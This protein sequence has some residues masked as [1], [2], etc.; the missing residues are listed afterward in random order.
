M[1]DVRDGEAEGRDRPR[2]R[3]RWG[4]FA[5]LAAAPVLIVGTLVV[6][7]VAFV[8]TDEEDVGAYVAEKADCG[9]ALA[10][11]GAALPEGAR[12]ESCT[13][14]RGIDTGYTAVFRMPRADVRGWLA[15]TYPA[16]P[17]PR[18]GCVDAD[19]DLCLD[20]G[21]SDALPPDVDAH[22]VQVTVEHSDAR[23]ALVRFSAFTI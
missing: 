14:A 5:A 17:A 11:G 15:G 6:G 22:G 23:T 1:T 3:T 21:H 8:L 16:A 12:T 7:L 9:Q 18:S 13:V 20:L 19:A 2:G 10:F 4:I